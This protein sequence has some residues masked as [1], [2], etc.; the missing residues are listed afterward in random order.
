ML[1]GPV[2][3]IGCGNMGSAM[4]RG[5][6]GAGADPALITVIDPAQPDA[7][8]GVRVVDQIPTGEAPPAIVL[9]AVKPQLL[10]SV[11]PGL[12]AAVNADTLLVSILAGVEIETLRAN[13]PLPRRVLRVMPNLPA[14]IGMG[15]S[16]LFGDGLDAPDREAAD[17]LLAPLGLVEWISSEAQ[18]HA[19]T[20]LSGSGPAFVFRFIEA[21]AD[22]GA[23]LGLPH[24]QALR[25]ALAT[26]EGS[27]A[28]AAADGESPRE[29]A[30]RVTSPNGT[31]QAGLERL[32][33][34]GSFAEAVQETLNAAARRSVQLAA[35][36]R[37]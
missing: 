21:L 15:V 16:A 11:A 2:W 6:L 27:A 34:A 32:D 29:L 31:T 9:L 35:E 5:W 23:Q 22:S 1:T 4:L 37:R 26:V 33:L 17:Q 36:A 7:Q 20:A 30:V 13:I 24:E 12:A 19:V 25:L 28:F 10:A 8:N 3:L 14:A 18:F